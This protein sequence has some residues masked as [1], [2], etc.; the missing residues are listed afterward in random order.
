MGTRHI[1]RYRTLLF[2]KGVVRP[3]SEKVLYTPSDWHYIT[4]FAPLV[5][6]L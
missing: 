4:N 5:T 6:V 3:F 1:L 2:R